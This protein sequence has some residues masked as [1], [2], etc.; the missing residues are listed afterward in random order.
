MIAVFS[1]FKLFYYGHNYICCFIN[2]NKNP[3]IKKFQDT[4]FNKILKEYINKKNYDTSR[5]LN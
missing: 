2:I 3:E 5:Q 4:F 1:F